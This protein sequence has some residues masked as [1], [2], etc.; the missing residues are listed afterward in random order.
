MGTAVEMLRT[1]RRR[2]RRS[3][4]PA[5]RRHVGSGGGSSH[6]RRL[7]SRPVGPVLAGRAYVR[8]M[9][10]FHRMAER[11]ADER[12]RIGDDEGQE[13]SGFLL[14]AGTIDD[15]REI[16]LLSLDLSDTGRRIL[17]AGKDEAPDESIAELD[18]GL[19]ESWSTSAL[20]GLREV[21]LGWTERPVPTEAFEAIASWLTPGAPS[22]SNCR[23]PHTEATMHL[24][25]AGT[26][27]EEAVCV[28]DPENPIFGIG[29]VCRARRR[30]LR[31]NVGRVPTQ[32]LRTPHRPEP[33][34]YVLGARLG[35][36]RRSLDASGHQRHR[37]RGRPRR[38]DRP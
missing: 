14:S 8:E 15:L 25:V 21:A 17:L 10:M 30:D 20:S 35:C 24:D 27:V 2:R 34:L 37:R 1:H 12:R 28:I 13:A 4:G 6:G 29:D 5:D 31:R 9:R 22:R 16:D 36:S 7:R 3:R 32:P 19:W 11:P 33:L 18:P 23:V 38:G 26:R